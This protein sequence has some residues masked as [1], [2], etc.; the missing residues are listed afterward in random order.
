MNGHVKNMH[1]Q[2]LVERAA[3]ILCFLLLVFVDSTKTVAAARN[4]GCSHDL[5]QTLKLTRF[6][7][8]DTGD[9][10]KQYKASQGE[11]AE[12][13]CKASVSDIP[14]PNISGLEPSEKTASMYAQLQAF[15]PHLRRVYEQQTD[16]QP[17]KSPLLNLLNMVINRTGMLTRRINNFYH[18]VF[19]NLPLP[20]PA[21][22]STTVP[23]PQNI[24]QQKVYGCVVLTTYK[25][26]LT[27]MSKNMRTLRSKVCRKAPPSEFNL[28]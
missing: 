1:F 12:L 15:A 2:Q 19:P 8:K 3:T 11:M 21:G 16:L 25:K 7:H 27:N 4:Q 5:H 10:I 23:S 14:D 9:L 20:E 24:F 13:L 18:K 6:V 28:F 26:L 17:P 22:G